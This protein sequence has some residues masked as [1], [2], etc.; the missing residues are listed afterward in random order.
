MGAR[1]A[2]NAPLIV[3]YHNGKV[4]VAARNSLVNMAEKKNDS[5]VQSGSDSR[6]GSYS[7]YYINYTDS[8]KEELICRRFLEMFVFDL[9]KRLFGPKDRTNPKTRVLKNLIMEVR[10]FL[11][12]GIRSRSR[13]SIDT[14]IDILSPGLDSDITKNIARIVNAV[15]VTI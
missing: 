13:V 11:R 8:E 7:K 10:Y 12:L 9:K 4:D 2:K 14:T 5:T 1:Q 6:E 15:Q 3:G